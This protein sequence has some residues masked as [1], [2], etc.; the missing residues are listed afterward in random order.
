MTTELYARRKQSNATMEIMFHETRRIIASLIDVLLEKTKKIIHAHKIVIA[1][2]THAK[3]IN[4]LILI[5]FCR[6]L[7]HALLLKIIYL[8]LVNVLI[9]NAEGIKKCRTDA[10][11]K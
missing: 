6:L 4:A 8:T 9:I 11:Q 3:K 5:M 2:E 1:L 7:L 10:R